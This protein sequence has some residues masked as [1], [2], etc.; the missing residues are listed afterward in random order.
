MED[1]VALT[2]HS[3]G[4]LTT[5]E[6]AS[7]LVVP[8][9]ILAQR[10]VRAKRKI[11]EAAL[12]F[13][14]PPVDRIGERIEGVMAVVYLIFTEGFAASGGKRVPHGE[15]CAEAVALG[16]TLVDLVGSGRV[17]ISAKDRSEVTALLALML[18]QLGGTAAIVEGRPLLETSQSM[19][20]TGFYQLQAAVALLLAEGETSGT[21][22]WNQI[23]VL[24]RNLLQWSPGPVVLLHY[25]VALGHVSGPSTAL[26]HLEPLDDALENYGPYH[27]ARAELLA[28]AKRYSEARRTYRN[29]LQL[30]RN[31]AE[32]R[33]ILER[34]GSLPTPE[35]DGV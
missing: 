13:E 11:Q 5:G 23:V 1:R 17:A 34:L 33:A 8:V 3:L 25:A 19:A 26:E 9:Q 14:V 21:T 4:G 12:K 10:L 6:I 7:A 24:Y 18:L 22:K 16:R 15:L 31:A 35:P 30:T 32:R 2:L 29:C 28:H 20:R 27:W